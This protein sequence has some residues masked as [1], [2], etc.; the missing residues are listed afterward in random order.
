V[1]LL[2]HIIQVLALA[3]ANATWQRT[4]GPWSRPRGTD[5]G[6]DP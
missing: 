3:Q 2:D 5:T 6:L 4:L 1:I